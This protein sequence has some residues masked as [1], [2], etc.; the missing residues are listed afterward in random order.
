MFVL[1]EIRLSVVSVRFKRFIG[2]FL[3]AR[4]LRELEMH[5]AYEMDCG[6]ELG[7]T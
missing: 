2:S 6:M 1:I 5:R 3:E 7:R 4:N